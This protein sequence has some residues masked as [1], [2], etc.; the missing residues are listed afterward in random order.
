M[1]LKSSDLSKNKHA[2][3]CKWEKTS[4]DNPIKEYEIK[5]EWHPVLP[6]ERDV[7]F[8]LKDGK[9]T[10]FAGLFNFCN[11][12]LPITTFYKDVLDDYA[13]HLS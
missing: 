5:P 8:P 6:S 4:S 10:L 11:F 3:Y 13:I 7:A 12:R 9:I 2:L 1:A